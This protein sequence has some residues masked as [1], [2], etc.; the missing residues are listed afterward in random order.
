MNMRITYSII[1]LQCKN[2]YNHLAFFLGVVGE[3]CLSQYFTQY[4]IQGTVWDYAIGT[5]MKNYVLWIS[6]DNKLLVILRISRRTPSI[7]FYLT[8]LF[9]RNCF[10][11]SSVTIRP[12]T[13]NNSFRI[14]GNFSG[15]NSLFSCWSGLLFLSWLDFMALHKKWSFPGFL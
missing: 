2:R 11:S 4:F 9:W 5:N 10:L 7:F 13:A 3:A 8:I 14:R 6:F 12:H 15:C 1:I